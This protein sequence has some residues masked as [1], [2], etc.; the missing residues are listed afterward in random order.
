MRK[1]LILSVLLLSPNSAMADDCMSK[2]LNGIGLE[3]C[4]QGESKENRSTSKARSETFQAIKYP[5]KITPHWNSYLI[6]NLDSSSE[7]GASL[8]EVSS[9]TGRDLTVS[10]GTLG[11]ARWSKFKEED[12]VSIPK[13]NIIGW[14]IVDQVNSDASGAAAILPGALFFPPMLLAAPFMI[15]NKFT[16]YIGI[17]YLNAFGEAQSVQLVS[18]S[19]KGVSL[20]TNLIQDVSGLSEG[21]RKTDEE[22]VEAYLDIERGLYSQVIALRDDLVVS[23]KKKPW[24][25]YID[26]KRFPNIY[27]KYQELQLRLHSVQ[28]KLMK[29]PIDFFDE[30]NRDARWQAYLAS[31]ENMAIWASLNKV[32][33]RKLRKCD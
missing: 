28:K 20:I 19:K 8:A 22:L 17:S 25:D 3:R 9:E 23:S 13:K 32:A 27:L 29:K 14:T 33:A 11:P 2:G 5:V 16:S 6:Y 30:S 18:S 7:D 26:K 21:V 12:S 24:C 10:T 15:S 4:L 1:A 31:N